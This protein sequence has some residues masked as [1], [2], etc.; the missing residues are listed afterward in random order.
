MSMYRVLGVL[1]MLGG[2]FGAMLASNENTTVEVPTQTILG[3]QV[4]GGTVHNLGLMQQQQKNLNLSIGVAVV[5][6]ILLG[7]GEIAG[8]KSKSDGT[9]NHK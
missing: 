9:T 7:I 1:L 4:G 8:R 6:V 3:K 5:G 2:F